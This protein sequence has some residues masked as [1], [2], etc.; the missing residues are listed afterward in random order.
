MY[1]RTVICL[2]NSRKPPSGR[3]FAGKEVGGQRAGQ[4]IRPVSDRPSREVSEE[5]RRYED[6]A[7]ASLLDIVKVA[8]SEHQPMGHQVENHILAEDHPWERVGKANWPQVR[9]LA[10]PFDADFWASGESTWNG[11]NDKLSEHVAAARSS[12]LKLILLPRLSIE[13]RLE[14]GFQGSP[15]RRRVRGRFD[16]HGSQYCLSVTDPEIEAAYLRSGL[17]TYVINDA[18]VCISLAEVWNGYAFRVIAS[19]ITASSF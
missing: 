5:E 8:L 17:G 11:V 7:R 14:D 16:Y 19:I 2:A 6:G 10:D 12:S 18:A 4:W 13:V 15:G 1:H 3:C 9:A